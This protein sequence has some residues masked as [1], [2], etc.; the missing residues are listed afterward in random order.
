MPIRRVLSNKVATANMH[1]HVFVSAVVA[2]LKQQLHVS[3]CMQMYCHFNG[4]PLP[5]ASL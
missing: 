1:R 5:S 2:K 3:A 4:K